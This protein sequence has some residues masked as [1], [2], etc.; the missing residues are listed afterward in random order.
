MP[1]KEGAM[2]FKKRH[3]EKKQKT[4][5]F[6]IIA[7]AVSINIFQRNL[8]NLLIGPFLL[9]RINPQGFD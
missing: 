6:Q 4:C 7:K 8:A 3:F 9:W 1:F 5:C 2:N